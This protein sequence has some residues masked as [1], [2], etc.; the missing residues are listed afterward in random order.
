MKYS[1]VFHK[2]YK[3]NE[4]KKIKHKRIFSEKEAESMIKL[5][6]IKFFKE[7]KELKKIIAKC[8]HRKYFKITEYTF[9]NPYRCSKRVKDYETEK[10]K[11]SMGSIIPKDYQQKRVYRWEDK[12][13]KKYGYFYSNYSR[14]KMLQFIS[15]VLEKENI[16][17]L[18]VSFTEKGNCCYF[19]WDY[20]NNK[21]LELKFLDTMRNKFVALHELSHYIVHYKNLLDEGHGEN[22]VG[23]YAYLLIKYIGFT[24]EKL[25]KS[26]DIEKINYIKKEEAEKILTS[27]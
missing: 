25:Y 21:I 3:D 26:L 23:I 22:F 5:L 15:Y 2:Y 19:R 17:P 16:P 18:N 1:I 6:A 10:I 9:N 8:V 13:F 24:E 4:E 12:N 14:K 7:D 20:F 11:K 27:L